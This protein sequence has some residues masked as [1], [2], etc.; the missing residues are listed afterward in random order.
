MLSGFQ[1]GRR[2]KPMSIISVIDDT[3][4]LILLAVLTGILQS[5]TLPDWMT[6]A[7]IL[8]KVLLF[9]AIAGGLGHILFPALGKYLDKSRTDEFGL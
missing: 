4:S 5:D 1:K 8:G 6:M 7:L 2:V 9:F 3:L